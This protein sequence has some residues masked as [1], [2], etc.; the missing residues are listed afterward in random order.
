MRKLL[1]R[2]LGD[3]RV[4]GGLLVLIQL[5]IVMFGVGLLS[6][7]W[8]WMPRALVVLSI[9]IVIWLVRKYDNP[10]YKI[11]WIVIILTLPLFGGLFYL[12]WGNTPFNRARTQHKYEPQPPDFNEYMRHPATEAL[13]ADNP[14]HASRARYIQNLDG[15]PAWTNTEAHYFRVGEEM[16]ESMCEELKKARRFIYMEYFIVE[17]GIMWDRV[18]SILSEKVREGVDIRL[19]Y[20][21][22]GCIATLPT[23]YDR[24]LGTLGIRAVRFN[25]FI[26]TL[27][28]YLN[29]RNHRKMM[30]IDGNV[31]YM[32]GINLADEYINEKVRFGHWKDTGILLRGEG[33]ASMTS[34]FLQMWEYAT[35]EPVPPLDAYL[36]T[37]KLPADGY[38]QPFADSP[39]DDLNISE[40]VY[41]QIIHTA[42][43]YVYI[44]TPYLVLDNEMITALTIAAQSGVD[45]RILTPGIPDKKLVYLITRSYYQQ[46]HRAGVKI[47]E[48]TPG[49]LHAKCIVSDDDT[50]VVGTINMDFRSFFLHF[51]CATCFYDSSVVHAVKEDVLETINKCRIVDDAWLRRV[52][53][54][55]SIAASVLRLFAPLL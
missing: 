21:D 47:Y 26:P 36:P 2:F 54:L 16:F 6:E 13:A 30:I 52:P 22:V 55:R 41:L 32:G 37:V 25:R 4:V 14:R 29:Y 27:N 19:I 23:N 20:D 5:V 40:S 46:L 48:Y 35:G 1:G 7:K 49:F 33:T 50:A 51:E 42:R 28:T 12:L 8:L 24:Y 9:I 44:T 3:R 38:V 15:M 17:E 10:T 53:W 34:L 39:L 11:S 43:E 18:L 45:V 31:G